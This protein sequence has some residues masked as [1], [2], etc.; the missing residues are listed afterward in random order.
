MG[1]DRPTTDKE[2]Q[3]M[4][5]AWDLRFPDTGATGAVGPHGWHRRPRL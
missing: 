5:E 1:R 2:E 4:L 3:P